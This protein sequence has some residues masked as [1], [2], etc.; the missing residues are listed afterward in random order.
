MSALS[1]RIKAF[2]QTLLHRRRFESDMDEEIRFHLDKQVE[3]GVAKGLSLQEAYRQARA[4]FGCMESQKSDMRAA[5]GKR[6]VDELVSDVSFALR[7]FR[8]SKV[9]TAIAVASIALAIG[10]NT[11]VFSLANQMLFERLAVPQAAQLRVFLMASGEQSVVHSSWGRSWQEGALNL[12]DSVP[13]PIFREMQKSTHTVEGIAGFK[14]LGHISA[15]VDGVPRS[16]QAQFVSGNFYELMQVQARLGRALASRDDDG[17][18]AGQVAVISDGFW[19]AAFGASSGVI[20][21]VITINGNPVTIVGVNPA[22]FTG[23]EGVERSPEVFLPLSCIGAF[24]EESAKE[25]LTKNTNRWWVQM[26]A[27][28]RAGVKDAVVAEEMTLALRNAVA[29]MTTPKQGEEIP[30]V[31]VKDGSHGMNDM[32]DFYRK[33][34]YT[35]L[36]MV[37]MVLLLACTNLAN[38]VLARAVTRNR[39]MSV[40]LALGAGRGRIMRQVL[41]EGLLLSCMGGTIGLGLGYAVR[42]VIPALLE[43]QWMRG[44]LNVPFNWHVFAFAAVVILLVGTLFSILP[45]WRSSRMEVNVGLKETGLSATKRR[46]AWTSKGLVMLQIALSTLLVIGSALFVQTLFKLNHMPTGFQIA[47][48]TQFQIIPP[49][50]RYKGK[51]STNLMER[52]EQQISAIPGVEGVTF[53]EVPLLA[54]STSDT[55]FKVEGM[56]SRPWKR[57]DSSQSSSYTVVGQD[58]FSVLKVPVLSGRAFGSQDTSTSSRVAV[59][60]QAAAAKF[61][62]NTNPIG[63]RFSTGDGKNGPTWFTV[64][65]V[66]A[67]TLYSSMRVPP[68]TLHFDLMRQSEDTYGAT[69]MVKSALPVQAIGPLLQ[70]SVASMDRDLPITN[71]QTFQDQIDD[72][73]GQERLFAN[74]AAGFGVLALALACIGVYGVMAYSV[75]QRTQE[76]GVR[77]ALGAARSQVRVMV[78]NEA[79]FLAVAGTV[80]GLIATAFTTKLVESTLYGVHPHD[81]ISMIFGTTTVMAVA[82][83]ACWVPA[84]RASRVEP[85]IAL[86]HE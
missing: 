52:I 2:V 50:K 8:K 36:G 56:S 41:I 27:R 59:I 60:N 53:S 21:R 23:A 43:N 6:W 74:L 11:A 39:E 33:S 30:H 82:L 24:Y 34:I 70:K 65:G 16:I 83:L 51:P 25:P 79:A 76:I 26:I 18:I 35:L 12:H 7:L 19:R 58:F 72:T 14:A 31:L 73:L 84:L 10:A 46:N 17:G 54:R 62:P 64:I 22:G 3:A 42:S 49:T 55:D 44:D 69:F 1:K 47:G 68:E 45:A 4:N 71:L 81:G 86:R 20:G 32:G 40:R 38:L 48:I 80:A 13:Y 57:E 67:N 9:F 66:C 85:L 77:L 28:S 15:T 5:F 78:M 29:T 61:F 63:R 37:G 75:S